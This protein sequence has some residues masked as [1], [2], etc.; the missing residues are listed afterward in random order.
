MINTYCKRRSSVQPPRWRID[1][2]SSHTSE[3]LIDFSK[4]ELWNGRCQQIVDEFRVKL[5]NFR[6]NICPT[7][8]RFQSFYRRTGEC[9][10]CASQRRKG[11]PSHFGPANDMDPGMV[12]FN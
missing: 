2:P 7:C 10:H 9:G 4:P 8:S 6:L 12:S 3:P 1:Q 11:N 5:E